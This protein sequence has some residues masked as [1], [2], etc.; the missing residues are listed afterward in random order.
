MAGVNRL[1]NSPDGEGQTELIRLSR[2]RSE[3][4]LLSLLPKLLADG[5]E[6]I[7]RD[8][9]GRTALHWATER[10]LHRYVLALVSAGADPALRC[11]DG[12]SCLDR[13]PE[14]ILVK[15]RASLIE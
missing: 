5:A 14:T 6:L 3:D 1:I 7:A 9:Q 4:E 12:W 2:E 11:A 10:Q 15:V 13:L 8:R